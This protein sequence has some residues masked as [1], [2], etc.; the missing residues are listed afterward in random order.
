MGNL[1]RLFNVLD[2]YQP[3]KCI[4]RGQHLCLGAKIR[5]KKLPVPGVNVAANAGFHIENQRQTL[6]ALAYNLSG[7]LHGMVSSDYLTESPQEPGGHKSHQQKG[8]SHSENKCA[9]ES[10]PVQRRGC[11]LTESLQPAFLPAYG[12]CR[13]GVDPDS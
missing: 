5:I 3:G 4:E 10:C 6:K 1:L 11:A 12:H 2:F 7:V 8:Q 9:P 13:H